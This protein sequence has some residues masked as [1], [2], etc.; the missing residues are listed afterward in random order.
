MAEALNQEGNDAYKGGNLS[1]ARAMYKQAV[2]QDEKEPKYASNLSAVLYEMGLY[3]E[4]VD[5][6]QRAWERIE[7]ASGAASPDNAFAIKLATRC[8]KAVYMGGLKTDELGDSLLR[9]IREQCGSQSEI[10]QVWA[11][12]RQGQPLLKTPERLRR[13]HETLAFKSTV[14]PLLEF[15]KSGHDLPSSLFSP[16]DDDDWF[17]IKDVDASERA[18]L[19]FLFAGVSDGRNVFATFLHAT[20]QPITRHLHLTLLD[21]HPS[22][23]A[24]LLVML[25]LMKQAQDAK[26]N[27]QSEIFMSLVSLY[28]S[29]LMPKYC[30]KRLKTTIK[31]LSEKLDAQSQALSSENP[32]KLAQWLSLSRESI[33]AVS[34]SLQHWCELDGKS[35]EEFVQSAADVNGAMLRMMMDRMTMAR[36][37]GPFKRSAKD[38]FDDPEFEKKIYKRLRILLPPKELLDRH[39][40]IK[41]LILDPQVTEKALRLAKEEVFGRMGAQ[42]DA[43]RRFKI[44]QDELR[45]NDISGSIKGYPEYPG[46]PYDNIESFYNLAHDIAPSAK[47]G[48]SIYKIL[49]SFFGSV[50]KGLHAMKNNFTIEC[51]VENLFGGL[52][53]LF[54]S[55]DRPSGYPKKYTRMF[56]SNIPDYTGGTLT[57]PIFLISHL[58]PSRANLIVWNDYLNSPAFQS[59]DEM[60][61]TYTQL[62][63]SELPKFLGYKILNPKGSPHTQIA[64]RS[65]PRQPGAELGVSKSRLYDWLSDILIAILGPCETQR[66]YRVDQPNNL[67]VFV[68]LLVHLHNHVGV[69]SHWLS[70][71]VAFLI[72]DSLFTTSVAHA[73][74]LPIPPSHSRNRKSKATR[75]NFDPW[76]MDLQ[77][78]ISHLVPLISFPLPVDAPAD[79]VLPLDDV[80][81]LQGIVKP[82]YQ[83]YA[84]GMRSVYNMVAALAFFKFAKT[85]Q[86][87]D[88]IL[89]GQGFQI[90]LSPM[91]VSLLEGFDVEWKM[92]KSWYAT[93]RKENWEMVVFRTDF[94]DIATTPLRASDWKEVPQPVPQTD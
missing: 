9:F 42:F 12:S 50:S 39:P 40:M 93:M 31:S 30:A 21:I 11:R 41:Q 67:G 35:S 36:D 89:K 78:M 7:R 34:R 80:V 58:H 72:N 85:N 5:A 66:P 82:T 24:K 17:T 32:V 27:E 74:P 20:R 70:D 8:T 86:K 77:M 33:P 47:I 60:N 6:I 76:R 54:V 61:Y 46:H 18:R 14:D 25:E 75:L 2:M 79:F 81:T 62:P 87:I 37:D 45:R 26:G 15:F 90:V 44:D 73:G 65:C 57:A 3:S 38:P 10:Q 68:H 71:Y 49:R 83:D 48:R 84:S 29:M 56:L 64:V 92:A 23:I 52:P 94:G 13:A 4:C 59:W 43:F 69:P 28:R 19:A 51:V 53:R 16:G 55:Q 22:V 63:A 1:R 88:N 91:R